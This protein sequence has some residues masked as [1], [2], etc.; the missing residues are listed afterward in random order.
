MVVY[1]YI[2]LYMAIYIWLY[3]AY[4]ISP[5]YGLLPLRRKCVFPFIFPKKRR[6]CDFSVYFPPN[7]GGW[8]VGWASF[9]YEK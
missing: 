2:W 8:A 6:K 9:L 1:G 7:Q 3:M 5:I 4:N